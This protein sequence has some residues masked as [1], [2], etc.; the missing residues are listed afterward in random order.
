MFERI[1]KLFDKNP[2]YYDLVTG[3]PR[4]KDWYKKSRIFI[5]KQPWC[6]ACGVKE[7]KNLVVHHKIPVHIAPELEMVET[8]WKVICETPS[9]NCHLYIAH[10]KIW[11]S[12]NKDIDE[13]CERMLLKIRN[14]P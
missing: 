5:T 6:S 3:K 4:H 9:M 1:I 8:N 10:L 12:Y 11:T 7:L 2:L 13:D 14:R